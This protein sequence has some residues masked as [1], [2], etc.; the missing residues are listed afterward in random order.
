MSRKIHLLKL[1]HSLMV[2]LFT[3]TRFPSVKLPVLLTFALRNMENKIRRH[4]YT[5]LCTHKFIGK[6]WRARHSQR[7]IYNIQKLV[8]PESGSFKFVSSP[9]APRL[10]VLKHIYS[11]CSL[12]TLR[13]GYLVVGG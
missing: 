9:L 4:I 11:L 7:H 5:F 2:H 1:L 3:F 10:D 12:G 13:S 6:S 8:V